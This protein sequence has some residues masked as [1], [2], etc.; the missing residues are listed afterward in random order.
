[1][2]TAVTDPW[3]VLGVDRSA[4]YDE[5]RHA[6]LIR[7]QL[8][9]PDRHQGASPDVLAEAQRAMREL[10]D[11]WLAVQKHLAQPRR[12]AEPIH[13]VPRPAGGDHLPDDH[14]S[15]EF[16]LDWAL[17]RL[18]D[19]A[20]AHGDPI[21]PDEMGRLRLPAAAA[22]RGRA[23][24]RWLAHRRLTL[25]QAIADDGTEEWTRALRVLAESGP[26]L[27]FLLL[28]DRR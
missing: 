7:S 10:S 15:P 8:L 19:A 25:R 22:P 14:A 13:P 20:R 5:A 9:H 23:F 6:Y 2:A 1:M 11:A 18:V 12:D 28:L 21:R 4:G 17:R 26:R 16:C 27:V 24:E 3:T